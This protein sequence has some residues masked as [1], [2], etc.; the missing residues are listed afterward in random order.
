MNRV[1][2]E[3]L[4]DEELLT[5]HGFQLKATC[6]YCGVKM[7]E[8]PGSVYLSLRGWMCEE[9]YMGDTKLHCCMR[10]YVRPEARP[11]KEVL[12]T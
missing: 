9:C 4:N 11:R 10:P 8:V 7:C 12:V 5:Q 1:P 6:Q 2:V 3:K